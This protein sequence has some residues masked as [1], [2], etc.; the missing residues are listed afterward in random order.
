[1]TWKSGIEAHI[2][3]T[4]KNSGNAAESV[5]FLGPSLSQFRAYFSGNKFGVK[6]SRFVM[7]LKS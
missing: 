1:M 6:T 2:Q 4:S 5:L 3:Y 7:I